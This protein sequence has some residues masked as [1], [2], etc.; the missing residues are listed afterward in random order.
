MW[1]TCRGRIAQAAPPI[2]GTNSCD[3][4]KREDDENLR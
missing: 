2:G 3:E 4:V 1:M